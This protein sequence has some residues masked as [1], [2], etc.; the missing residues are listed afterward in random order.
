MRSWIE[1][2]LLA[3]FSAAIIGVLV[4]MMRWPA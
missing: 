1:L 3:L 4:V 2:L